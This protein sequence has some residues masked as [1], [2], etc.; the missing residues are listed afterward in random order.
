MARYAA[1]T[2]AEAE[3]VQLELLRRKTPAGRGR[4]AMRLSAD[5]VN[6]AKQARARRLPHADARELTRGFIEQQYGVVTSAFPGQTMQNDM[7][8]ALKPV[9]FALRQLQA[10][11]YIGGSVASSIHGTPRSTLDVDLAVQLDESAGRRLTELLQGDFY[12]SWEAVRAAIRSRACFNL[13][14]FETAWKVDIFVSRE[15]PFDLA[16]MRRA[17]VIP[18]GETDPLDVPVAA[19]EDIILFKLEW[20]A[21]GSETSER[22]WNDVVQV[23]KLQGDRLDRALLRHGGRELALETLLERLLA[24]V[25]KSSAAPDER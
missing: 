12:V 16:A 7:L 2:T 20:Y 17:L 15:R 18:L 25:S 13:I 14:H 1:D 8:T 5:L 9:V 11:H 6:A 23:A 19:P 10:P 24:E 21:L 3:A 4:L 22:Q